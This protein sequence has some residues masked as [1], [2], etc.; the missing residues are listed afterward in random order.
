MY[1]N[2][3]MQCAE[4]KHLPSKGLRSNAPVDAIGSMTQRKTGADLFHYS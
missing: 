4:K 3:E 1:K 2:P